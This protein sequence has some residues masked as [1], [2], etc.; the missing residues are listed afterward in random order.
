LS[1]GGEKRLPTLFDAPWPGRGGGASKVL[2]IAP[3]HP[4]IGMVR[5]GRSRAADAAL[6]VPPRRGCVP[7]VVWFLL[8]AVKVAA[9]SWMME[10][11]LLVAERGRGLVSRGIMAWQSDPMAL[12]EHSGT[13]CVEGC[14]V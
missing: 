10:K 1:W 5:H 2:A 12:A 7:R 4:C 9:L 8:V 14:L 13:L 6:W 11:Q 3:W